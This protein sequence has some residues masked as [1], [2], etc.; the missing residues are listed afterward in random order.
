MNNSEQFNLP[1]GLYTQLPTQNNTTGYNV[2]YNINDISI[3]KLYENF[4][5]NI[6]IQLEEDKLLENVDICLNIINEYEKRGI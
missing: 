4:N 1:T 2:S 5:K 6:E 3:D